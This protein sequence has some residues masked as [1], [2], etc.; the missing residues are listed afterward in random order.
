MCQTKRPR[1]Y[2]SPNNS[3]RRDEEEVASVEVVCR[4]TN[5]EN[6]I[7]SVS[8]APTEEKKASS[9][10][11]T[12]QNRDD[13]RIE[14]TEWDDSTRLKFPQSNSQTCTIKNDIK[15]SSSKKW[16]AFAS[17]ENNY[18]SSDSSGDESES[19]SD[20][21]YDSGI[22]DGYNQQQDDVK[23]GD[24]PEWDAFKSL[25]ETLSD[26][27]S[28]T[29]GSDDEESSDC[30]MLPDEEDKKMPPT[31]TATKNNLKSECVDLVD[32]DEDDEEEVKDKKPKRVKL[33]RK[34]NR[35]SNSKAIALDDDSDSSYLSEV[36]SSRPL[37]SSAS[38]QKRSIPPWQLSARSETKSL[39]IL[40]NDSILPRGSFSCL[41]GRNDIGG[42]N[43]ETRTSSAPVLA[44]AASTRQRKTSTK[45]GG[46][47]RR[48]KRSNSSTDAAAPTKKK[49]RTRK[50]KRSSR[51]GGRG[52]RGGA[53]AASSSSRSNNNAWSARERGIRQ[54]IRANNG[55]GYMNITKQEPMLQNIGGAS[56]QF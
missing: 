10:L 54:P 55:S 24:K 26:D 56:I 39:S 1:N 8:A 12:N 7:C 30:I 47:R 29:S 46:S 20:D 40:Q 50:Y 22:E 15:Q 35:S 38:R 3:A 42:T 11:A 9:S 32:T 5:I 23:V 49:R 51:R 37:P 14:S 48:R 27:D 53:A 31:K 45:S 16:D 6:V 13:N 4:Q 41:N 34:R 43:N 21:S 36:E 18:E 2:L 52:G 28:S 44:P 19:D 25:Q 33:T 17:L